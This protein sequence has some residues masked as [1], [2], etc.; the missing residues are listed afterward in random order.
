VD[1]EIHI[2]LP[3]A[4]VEDV[5]SFTPWPLYPLENNPCNFHKSPC[6]P[7]SRSRRHG[8]EKILDCNR[9]RNPTSGRLS[10]SLTSCT[11]ITS[12]LY[13]YCAIF[14]ATV[15]SQPALH[16]GLLLTFRVPYLML[17]FLWLGSFQ[18]IRPSPRTCVTLHTLH[19]C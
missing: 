16:I 10:S 17:I 14:H 9:T 2:F 13:S 7:Q 1:V 19:L 5:V 15:I 11:S 12:H 8:V 6:G 4:Q 3:S 18:R